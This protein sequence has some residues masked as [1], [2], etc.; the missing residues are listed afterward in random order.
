MDLLNLSA[1]RKVVMITENIKRAV[2]QM[3][4]K[5]YNRQNYRKTLFRWWNNFIPY[6]K[7]FSLHKQL[8]V[9]HCLASAP[10]Q[11]L[12]RRSWHRCGELSERLRD[13]LRRQ[14]AFKGDAVAR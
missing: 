10:V 6:G 5:F 12:S 13:S 14:A 7:G 9:R 1:Y 8:V 2:V 11:L 3:W 4:T